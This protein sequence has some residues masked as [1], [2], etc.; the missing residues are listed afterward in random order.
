MFGNGFAR[1]HRPRRSEI[2]PACA[3]RGKSAGAPDQHSGGDADG[4]VPGKTCDG[5]V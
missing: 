4:N 1:P 5:M 2:S 3:A